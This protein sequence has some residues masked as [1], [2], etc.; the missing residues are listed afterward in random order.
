MKT[1]TPIEFWFVTGSQH[2]YGEAELKKVAANSKKIIAELGSKLPAKL[3]F[4]PV[5]AGPDEIRQLCHDASSRNAPADSVDAFSRRRWTD[6][7]PEAVPAFAR[8]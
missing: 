6:L 7:L 8:S 5:M 3:V 1:L 2:L 4:K